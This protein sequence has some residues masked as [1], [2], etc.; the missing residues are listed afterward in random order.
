MTNKKPASVH[1]LNREH[2]DSIGSRGR[3]VETGA[4][5]YVVGG[6]GRIS[7]N[8]RDYNISAEDFVTIMPGSIVRMSGCS[9]DFEAYAIIFPAGFTNDLDLWKSTLYSLVSVL[10]NPVLSIVGDKNTAFVRSYCAILLEMYGMENITFRD[11][12][13]K[14]MLQALMFAVSGFYRDFSLSEKMQ[15]RGSDPL[16]RNHGLFKD[17][18][19][20]VMKNYEQQR[21]ISFYADKLCITPKHL[22]YVVKS[23]SGETASQ[24][25]A[26]A[27][28]MDAKSRLK[29]TNLSVRQISDELYFP[30]PSFFGKYFR[31]HT[32]MTPKEYRDNG[33]NDDAQ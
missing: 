30:N 7:A 17:F 29:T 18:I 12:I 5:I 3:R 1:M 13:I 11:E 31:K 28:I 25:I 32:G 23:V 19:S 9:D 8:L 26:R 2:L 27:V 4:F 20:L 16:S 21:E 6:K 22:G 10:E 15:E 24:F 14:N 33:D